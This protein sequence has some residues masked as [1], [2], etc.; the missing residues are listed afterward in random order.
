MNQKK[1]F[2]AALAVIA[3]TF[4]TPLAVWAQA[5]PRSFTASPEVYKVIAE[6][7]QYRVVEATWKPGQ[8]DNWHSHGGAALAHYNVTGCHARLH[9][10]DGKFREINS[11]AG[12][13]AIRTR[14]PSHSFENVG[15][16]ECK[17][18]FFEP[19]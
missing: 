18:V 5:A 14:G 16:T 6:N 19:K 7:E 11:K 3:W 15:K 8:R 4:A 17:V 12:R 2:F 9:T 13:A 10:P 1:Q